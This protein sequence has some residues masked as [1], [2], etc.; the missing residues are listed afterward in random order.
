MT[1]T[2]HTAGLAD[3]PDGA[4]Y[5]LEVIDPD[6]PEMSLVHRSI[7]TDGV[8]A[9]TTWNVRRRSWVA[10]QA[11][12]SYVVGRGDNDLELI[13]EARAQTQIARLQAAFDATQ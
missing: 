7:V 3:R 6:S 11:V 12:W 8:A 9:D 10:S 13:D 4:Y 1:E 5:Y 2:D